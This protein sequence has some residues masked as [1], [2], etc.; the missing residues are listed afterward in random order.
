M[1][2]GTFLLQTLAESQEPEACIHILV[3]P[4]ASHVILGKLLNLF[5]PLSPH[6]K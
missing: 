1:P 6:F 5:V 2:A 4:F 3:P